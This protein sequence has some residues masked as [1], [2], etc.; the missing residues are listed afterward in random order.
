MPPSLPHRRARPVPALTAE[1]KYRLVA[2]RAP[3]CVFATD[4]DG[5]YT[6][7]EGAAYAA[8]GIDPATLV[9]RSLFD[10]FAHVK[11]SAPLLRRALAGEVATGTVHMPNERVME[12]H[13]GPTRDDAGVLTGAIG[14]GIDVT[15]RVRA[16]RQLRTANETLERRVKER[17][18]ELLAVNDELQG[19]ANSL[20]H[21][22]RSPLR[23]MEGYADAVAREAGD[24]LSERSLG[25]LGR[26][27]ANAGRMSR[28]IDELLQLSRVNRV[29][30]TRQ[31]VD[32]TALGRA[33]AEAHAATSRD[34]RV[35]VQIDDGMS[36]W[37]DASLLRI[38]IDQLLSNAWKFTART[39]RPAVVFERIERPEGAV[40]VIRDNGPGFEMAW[41][42][43][44]FAPF[45]RVHSQGFEGTGIG[46]ALVKRIVER[47]GGEVWADATPGAGAAFYFTLPM[48]PPS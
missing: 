16:E 15:D 32:L 25:Y 30:M 11:E 2:G 28:L 43:Q 9:G 1:A 13:L 20:A 7:A 27:R 40:F 39:E 36:A 24:R 35:E 46:L 12:V 3:I 41:A 23:A 48:A 34:R 44:L 18:A 5:V 45:Q 31:A 8:I 10:V 17:T 33:I 38:V 6:M 22:L 4:A 21:D 14:L 47:H 42:G 19:L 29:P 26:I 37:G